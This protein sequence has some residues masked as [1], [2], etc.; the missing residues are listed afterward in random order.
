MKAN[1][2]LTPRERVLTALRL[3]EPDRIP[4]VE[5]YMH[6][7]LA[8][9]ILGKL[10]QMPRNLRISPQILEVLN[11]DNL[12]YNLKPPEFAEKHS[13]NGIEFVGKGLIKTKGDLDMMKQQLPDPNGERLY[14]PLKECIRKYRKDY[15]FVVQTRFGIANTYLS[16]GMDKF[17]IALY[18]D[19]KFVFAMMNNFIDWTK[20]VVCHIQD[21]DVD[22]LVFS[23]DLASKSGPLFSPKMIRELF[24][25]RIKKI[26]EKIELPWIYHSDG[27]YLPILDD[28]LTLG[29]DGIANLEPGAMDL[30]ELKRDYGERVCLM[31][32]I[33]LH[34]TLTRGTMEETEREVKER[35]REAGPNGGYILASS[36]GLTLYCKKENVK[37]M[38]KIVGDSTY[39]LKV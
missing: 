18:K 2:E 1:I 13:R 14:E 10:A 17:S 25:P 27:N 15:A 4:W 5:L 20:D 38:N 6:T 8:E 21:L 36:N 12:T 16:M 29:M 11:L 34:Y 9:D 35:I 28:L 32:N 24:I 31:G 33:D 7:Q 3:K 23:D 37:A 30:A 22:V 26:T 39:P 19:P